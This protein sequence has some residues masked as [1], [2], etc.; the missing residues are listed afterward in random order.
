VS[1]P[2]PEMAAL[3]ASLRLAAGRAAVADFMW[4]ED[5]IEAGTRNDLDAE[6]EAAE[7][8]LYRAIAKLEAARAEATRRL[9]VLVGAVEARLI[10]ASITADEMDRAPCGVCGSFAP[11]FKKW[12]DD[13]GADVRAALPKDPTP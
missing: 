12:I 8:S 7:G 1:A 4:G 6:S 3:V 10:A 11:R 2:S 13:F 9:A 5:K